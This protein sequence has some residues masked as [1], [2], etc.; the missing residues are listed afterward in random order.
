MRIASR[1]TVA[2][3]R[4]T[5]ARILVVEDDSDIAMGLDEDLTRHGHD[6]EIVRDGDAAVRRGQQGTWDVILLDV[7]LPHRDGFEVCR[8]LR[9]LRVKT[10]IIMLTARTQEAEKILGL[11][12]GADDYVTKPFSPAE[13]RARIKAVM[14]RFEDLAGDGT[15]RFGECEVDFERAEVRRG[16]QPVDV[17]ALE[18]RLL[19]ALVR[20]RGRVLTRE[21]LI[22]QAWG[23]DTHIGDRVV[24]TH[25]LN[26]R[27]KIE[28]TPAEPRFVKSVR[29]M[30][31]RFDE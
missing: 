23:G 1:S 3:R 27:K 28:P 31:Y 10:P 25:I 19:A 6:V 20:A 11:E 5:V 13:L 16:G 22:Q 29:G 24:D 26:L 2:A 21:Q 12:F 30:G 4:G 7:M 9:R 14:R 15:C 8:E 17:T 18:L